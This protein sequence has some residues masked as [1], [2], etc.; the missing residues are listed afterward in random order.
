MS[1]TGDVTITAG[2]VGAGRRGGSFR[3]GLEAAGISAMAVCDLDAAGLAN[4][5]ARVG[6][7]AVPG[8]RADARPVGHRRGDHRHPDAAPRADV[9]RCAGARH[10]HCTCSTA[11]RFAKGSYT[12]P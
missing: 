5:A 7:A 10:P 6:A 3:A 8:L 9:D 2:I 11:T 4:T 1:A 12:N